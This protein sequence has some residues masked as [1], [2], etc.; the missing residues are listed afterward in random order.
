MGAVS[1]WRDTHRRANPDFLFAE[2]I[3]P[4]G[5][6]VVV[7]IDQ[8]GTRAKLRAA[9]NNSGEM[10]WCTFVGKKKKFG[11][12]RTNCKVLETLTG[13]D[14]PEKWPGTWMVLTVV[15]AG[16]PDK[17]THARLE[18]NAI[19][20][21]PAKPSPRD[22]DDAIARRNRSQPGKQSGPTQ[23]TPDEIAEARR[24]EREDSK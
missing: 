3:G 18:T 22:I 11:L 8:A 5:T 1:S 23:M 20:I 6:S 21:A 10:P 9:G 15:R 12:N 14:D 2:D 4:L 17:D 24:I 16:Y 7:Q 13:T 19:R